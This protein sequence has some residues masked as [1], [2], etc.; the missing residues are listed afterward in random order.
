MLDN[1]HDDWVDFFESLATNHKQIAH[2]SN[3]RRFFKDEKELIGN[4]LRSPSIVCVPAISKLEGKLHNAMQNYEFELWI[5]FSETDNKKI[6]L[7]RKNA[8]QIALDFL[9]AIELY[10][11][12]FDHPATIASF[13]INNSSIDVIGPIGQNYHGAAL[14]VVVGSTRDLTPDN[15]KWINPIVD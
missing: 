9:S 7:A 10:A 12:S 2:N 11:S 8:E 4:N 13:N 5:L 6:Q 15:S 1:F 14:T 3:T